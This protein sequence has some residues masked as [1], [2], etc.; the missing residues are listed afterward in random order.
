VGQ[1]RR[2]LPGAINV[3]MERR[4]VKRWLADTTFRVS[5]PETK[6]E[7]MSGGMQQKVLVGRA[8][9][10]HPDLLILH[11]P[12]QGIDVSA[13][14]D[15]EKQILEAAG[16]GTAVLLVSPEHDELVALC[17]SV[18]V[19]GEEQTAVRLSGDQLSETALA[20]SI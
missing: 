11:E 9:L 17:D 4:F 1:F 7:A 12:T 8:L 14:A 13:R 20:A 5:G 10:D 19:W 16:S 18:I 6:L 2:G 3:R 15:I